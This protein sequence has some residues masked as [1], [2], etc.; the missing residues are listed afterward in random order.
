M[1]KKNMLVWNLISTLVLSFTL[2]VN[3]LLSPGIREVSHKYSTII[4]PIDMTFSIWGIIYGFALWSLIIFWK[5]WKENKP[6]QHQIYLAYNSIMLL[7][8]L[9]VF[10]WLQEM[11]ILSWFIITI[12]L[13]I[14]AIINYRLVHQ[15]YHASKVISVFFEIHFS[16]ICAAFFLNTLVVW[17]FFQGTNLDYGSVFISLVALISITFVSNIFLFARNH[18]YFAMAFLWTLYGILLNM[19][20][21]MPRIALLV[22]ILFVVQIIALSLKGMIVL[23]REKEFIKNNNDT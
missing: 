8:S 11:L 4:T 18:V 22:R 3:Y 19:P 1:W 16:W 6:V 13:A 9:W 23:I 12:I 14:L 7:N 15:H 20:I 5:R 10:V 17:G 2:Y 21:E